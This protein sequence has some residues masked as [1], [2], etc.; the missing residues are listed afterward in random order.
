[1]R[2]ILL[3]LIGFAIV[4][5][6]QAPQP[7]LVDEFATLC[8]DDLRVR[9]DN[10][11]VAIY[12]RPESVGYVVGNAEATTPGRLHKYFRVFQN[13]VQFRR[14]DVNRLRYFRGTNAESMRF[15]LWLV[16][17]EAR[18]PEIPLSFPRE[19]FENSVMFDASELSFTKKGVVEFGGEWGNEPC[20]FGLDLN[21]FAIVLG[22]NPNLKGYLIAS[23]ISRG[24][25]ANAKKALDLTKSDLVRNYRVPASSIKTI[26]AGNRKSRVM[27]LWLVPNGSQ[28]PSFRENSV[29]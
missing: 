29:P 23:S 21:Q 26:F 20:D 10:F 24:D 28:T 17:K 13:H 18:P 7:V 11:L 5:A 1:M 25:R 12:E 27:Q 22:A 15:Q 4:T 6:A 14:F 8:S 16:P 19:T 9:L 3:Y 2:L